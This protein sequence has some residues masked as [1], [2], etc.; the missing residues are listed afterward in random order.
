MWIESMD[1]IHDVVI[2]FCYV[3]KLLLPELEILCL[4]SHCLRLTFEN[5]GHVI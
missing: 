2:L 1:K 5:R 4:S 3:S